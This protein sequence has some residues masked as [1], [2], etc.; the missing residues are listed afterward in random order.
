[1][2]LKTYIKKHGFIMSEKQQSHLGRNICRSFFTHH[3][4]TELKK[5]VIN[6][7]GIKMQV[8]DYPRTF[9]ESKEF[10]TVLIRYITKN[11]IRKQKL[12]V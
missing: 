12:Y 7:N 4:N 8:I 3:P 1:M 9:F 6:S 5:V 2:I 11:S 10:I